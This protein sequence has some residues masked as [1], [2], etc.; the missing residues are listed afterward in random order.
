MLGNNH[1]LFVERTMCYEFSHCYW[2]NPALPQDVEVLTSV[3]VNVTLLGSKIFA[4]DQVKKNEVLSV[5]PN[6]V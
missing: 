1:H 3:S 6:P 2:L 4:N 5:G